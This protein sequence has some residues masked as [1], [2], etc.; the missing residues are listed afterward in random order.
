M[1]IFALHIFTYIFLH[2]YIFYI[3]ILY[4]RARESIVCRTETRRTNLRSGCVTRMTPSDFYSGVFSRIDTRY[5][6][7]FY[8]PEENNSGS[9]GALSFLD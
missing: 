6:I 5:F 9:H 1:Y 8:T 7:D 4:C 2:I 3:Y